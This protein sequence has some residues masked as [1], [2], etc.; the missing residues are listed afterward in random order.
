[1]A[2]VTYWHPLIGLVNPQFWIATYPTIPTCPFGYPIRF[3]T[4]V[5]LPQHA[6]RALNLDIRSLNVF[7]LIL[8]Y[9]TPSISFIRILYN[10][11]YCFVG[12]FGIIPPRTTYYFNVF[13]RV[14]NG[15][16]R[17]HKLPI[18][19]PGHGIR[20]LALAMRYPYRIGKTLAVIIRQPL[21]GWLHLVSYDQRLIKRNKPIT[22]MCTN[23]DPFISQT[24][25]VRHVFVRDIR[26]P[27]YVHI[28]VHHHHRG[29]GAD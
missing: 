3:A 24:P 22:T 1:M 27:F 29:Y 12:S 2:I 13:I 21:N 17:S 9:S 5:P 14:A 6:A 7:N 11:V 25:H 28:V 15:N 23:G 18:H 10:L 8:T 4:P 19:F 16:Q 26:R 20:I